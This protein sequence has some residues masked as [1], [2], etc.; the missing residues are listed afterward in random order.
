MFETTLILNNEFE[1]IIHNIFKGEKLI[2]SIKNLSAII[3]KLPDKSYDYPGIYFDIL[4]QLAWENISII[5]VVSTLNEFSII[6]NQKDIDRGFSDL[7][8]HLWG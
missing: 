1:K 6:L 7:K 5:E 3:L 4:K 2:S 8:S